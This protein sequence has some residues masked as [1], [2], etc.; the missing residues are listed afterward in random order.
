MSV[1]VMAAAMSLRCSVRRLFS[2]EWF[3][4]RSVS[5]RMNISH[6]CGRRALVGLQP[7]LVTAPQQQSEGAAVLRADCVCAHP[8]EEHRRLR[9]DHPHVLVR[10][11]DLRART[12]A[13]PLRLAATEQRA[14]APAPTAEHSN[15]EQR[16]AFFIRASGSW[17]F[18]N[19]AGSVPTPRIS[20]IC[21]CQNCRSCSFCCAMS[22]VMYAAGAGKAAGGKGAARPA[23]AQRAPASAR[24]IPA[25]TPW[26]HRH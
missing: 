14:P 10:L 6:A 1:R 25:W 7:R 20:C 9:A 16:H 15:S 3:Q 4:D 8:R 22:G 18:L 26:Q 19:S 13:V 2:S 24:A 11:H 21:W 17:W 12:R 5:S 23:C